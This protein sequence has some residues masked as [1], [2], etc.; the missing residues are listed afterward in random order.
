MWFDGRRHVDKVSQVV[1]ASY[2][3]AMRKMK[4]L[5]GDATKPLARGPLLIPHICNDIGAWGAGFVLAISKRWPE[6][7]AAYR[8]WKQE[9]SD[10]IAGRFGLGN[11]QFVKCKGEVTL[12]NMIAQHNV[13]PLEGKLPIRYDALEICLNK[14]ADYAIENKMVIQMP[15]IGTGLA[16]G[17]WENIEPIIEKTLCA[18]D[19]E[20]NVF[21][22]A[23]GM[24]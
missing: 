5:I 21:D 4:Y 13:R 14:V 15:R 12:A 16:G 9:H 23:P 2:N 24:C 22:L 19:L 7:E 11:V 17:L 18:K 1:Q 8:A 3:Y 10:K 6:P 20:V